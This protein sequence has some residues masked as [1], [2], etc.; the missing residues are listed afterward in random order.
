MRTDAAEMQVALLIHEGYILKN[1]T[2]TKV[3]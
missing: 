1:T 3:M 2:Q